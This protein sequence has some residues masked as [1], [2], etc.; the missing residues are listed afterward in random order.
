MSGGVL[1]LSYTLKEF[2][3]YSFFLQ[4]RNELITK[5]SSS[6]VAMT[7]GTNYST[8]NKDFTGYELIGRRYVIAIS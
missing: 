3:N 7:V 2:R 8:A 4:T 1:G 6:G 5:C